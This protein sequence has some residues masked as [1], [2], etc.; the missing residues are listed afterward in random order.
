MSSKPPRKNQFRK[1]AD[2]SSLGLMLPSSIAIG[3]FLGYYLDKSLGTQPWLLIIFLLLG[4]ASG[5]ISL[6]RGLN[7][8][9]NDE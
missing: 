8:Y 7:R 1:I 4:I 5:L 2:L 9:K 6:I 3:L